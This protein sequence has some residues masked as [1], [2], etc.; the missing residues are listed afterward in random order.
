M[1]LKEHQ[2]DSKWVWKVLIPSL[3]FLYIIW[4]I[5]RFRSL[6]VRIKKDH[7]LQKEEYELQTNKVLF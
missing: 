7:L 4:D 2:E 3:P 6:G 5:S 1:T